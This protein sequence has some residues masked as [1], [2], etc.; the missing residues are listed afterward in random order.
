MVTLSE[1]YRPIETIPPIVTIKELEEEMRKF[2]YSFGKNQEIA[3][4]KS[5]I[6]FAESAVRFAPN[7]LKRGLSLEINVDDTIDGTLIISADAIFP[8]KFAQPFV[9]YYVNERCGGYG[10]NPSSPYSVIANAI[11]RDGNLR[12]KSEILMAN[13]VIYNMNELGEID[14][15]IL[16]DPQDIEFSKR[17]FR[18]FFQRLNKSRE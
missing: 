6:R 3:H 5:Y 9:E 4:L 18:S 13:D 17:L 16:M 7:F 12:G 11:R 14:G 10:S 8:S 1:N 15:Q 2:F